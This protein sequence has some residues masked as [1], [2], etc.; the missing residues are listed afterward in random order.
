MFLRSRRGVNQ[1]ITSYQ[2]SCFSTRLTSVYKSEV[3]LLYYYGL[4]SPI[5]EALHNVTQI[6]NGGWLQSTDDET[7]GN[8][9]T[10]SN[11][12]AMSFME[13][14][15]H[16]HNFVLEIMNVTLWAVSEKLDQSLLL[17]SQKTGFQL[18]EEE[19]CL[20]LW[21]TIR[22]NVNPNRKRGLESTEETI[23]A[24]I[25]RTVISPG[26][27]I[28]HPLV[29]Q[30]HDACWNPEAYKLYVHLA[31][32]AQARN[33]FANGVSEPVREKRKK[34]KMFLQ[35][36]KFPRPIRNKIDLK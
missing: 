7:M 36:E 33:K 23:V 17:I 21:D 29:L 19:T 24:G 31:A 13:A 4:H 22:Q 9:S 26:A 1:A 11:E 5:V 12:S 25:G 16:I 27:S 14:Y 15:S 30:A 35:N 6:K 2:R 32:V 18:Y 8:H 3:L 20:P 28:V 10:R 34:Y